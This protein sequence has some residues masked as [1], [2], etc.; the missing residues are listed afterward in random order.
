MSDLY[1]VIRKPCLTEKANTLQEGNNQIVLQVAPAANKIEIKQAVEAMFNVK[2]DQVRTMNMHGK[3][4]RLGRHL[5]QRADWK[6]AVV[7]LAEG[8]TLDFLEGL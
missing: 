7:T 1:T 6:K 8:H 4:K 5:G 3:K 2:V